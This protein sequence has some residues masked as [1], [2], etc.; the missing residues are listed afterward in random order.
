MKK[1]QSNNPAGGV[2]ETINQGG[3][4]EKGGR[5][6]SLIPSPRGGGQFVQQGEAGGIRDGKLR[7]TFGLSDQK[8]KKKKKNH[9]K[10]KGRGRKGGLPPI[11]LKS[12]KESSP[13]GLRRGHEANL[14]FQDTQESELLGLGGEVR[15]E[16]GKWGAGGLIWGVGW[17]R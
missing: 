6:L 10:E 11:F 13:G 1:Q 8:K 9:S 3:L 4:L 17:E 5:P 16:R 15:C 7:T 2:P 14:L 12:L